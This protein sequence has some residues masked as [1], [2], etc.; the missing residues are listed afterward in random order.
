MK[1][2]KRI[3]LAGGASLIL[4]A[5]AQAADL[6]VKA[7]GPVNCLG[8]FEAWVA[9]SAADCPLSAYGITFYGQIDM[10]VS[11]LQHGAPFGNRT[12][13][14]IES[15]ISPQGNRSTFQLSDNQFSPSNIGVRVSEPL[16]GDFKFIADWRLAFNPWSL[17]ALNGPGALID[18]NG[19]APQLR[20][21]VGSG[22]LNGAWDNN[23]AFVGFASP[24]V[25]TFKIGRINNFDNDLFPQYNAS[26]GSYGFSGLGFAGGWSTGL[27]ITESN[28]FNRGASYVYDYN[29]LFHV[30]AGTQL[31]GYGQENVA[32]ESYNFNI[33]GAARGFSGDLIYQHSTDAMHFGS[34]NVGAPASVDLSHNL[35]ATM[36]NQDAIALLT[37]YN[38]QAVTVYGS[39]SWARLTNPSNSVYASGFTNVGGSTYSVLPNSIAAGSIN[40]TAYTVPEILQ[41][42]SISAK[43][44]VNPQFDVMVDY[45]HIW[46]NN[47]DTNPGS[48]QA[49]AN[50]SAFNSVA[51]TYAGVGTIKPDC[52]GTTDVISILFDYRPIKRLDTYIGVEYSTGTGGMVSGFWASSNVAVTSGVRL[53]F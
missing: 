14:P 15:V 13:N 53:T 16:L 25:G 39:Y 10:G 6:P 36:A 23:R 11:Y 32:K 29:Q 50:C 40:T 48:G 42:A 19:V 38:Y 1:A 4:A 51:Q 20:N 49:G 46:Q 18:N 24:T 31:G 2:L 52:S 7:R 3:L 5:T 37:K 28:R 8:S 44:A 41:T 17:Q 27:G 26:G 45:A 22:S 34:W 43:Y 30:G 21:S 47:Y 33:G 12:P 9:A 35:K